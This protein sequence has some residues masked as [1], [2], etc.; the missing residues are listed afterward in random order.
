M[1]NQSRGVVYL[2]DTYASDFF[3]PDGKVRQPQL[4]HNSCTCRDGHTCLKLS[5]NCGQCEHKSVCSKHSELLL[6]LLS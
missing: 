2:A 1:E 3:T 6:E 5:P 4:H